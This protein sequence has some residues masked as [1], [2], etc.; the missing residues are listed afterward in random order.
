MLS[1]SIEL[2]KAQ[3]RFIRCFVLLFVFG[4]PIYILDIYRGRHSDNSLKSLFEF[5]PMYKNFMI[6][7]I[8]LVGFL[9][10]LTL[11]A[12][13]RCGMIRNKLRQ[14]ERRD[15]DDMRS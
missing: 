14:D 2:K 13:V 9:I 4:S 8:I 15:S 10:I 3:R 12:F 7:D 5:H 1:P 6:L 11:Y